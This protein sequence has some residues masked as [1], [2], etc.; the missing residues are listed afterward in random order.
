MPPDGDPPADP[1][2]GRKRPRG[3]TVAAGTPSD[4]H[5]R[6]PLSAP[7]DHAPAP[8]RVAVAAVHPSM[9]RA[10]AALVESDLGLAL[11]GT[12]G[13][14]LGAARL[15]REGRTDV[16]LID[17]GLAR[18]S[19]DGTIRQIRA[20]RPG[21]AVLVTGMEDDPAYATVSRAAGAAGFVTADAPAE[22]L[23]AAIHA[24]AAEPAAQPA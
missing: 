20:L 19:T 8:V 1:G 9:R 5:P 6:V 12:V 10:L 16:L 3:S 22:D 18:P 2:F 7:V 15:V 11:A 4:D 17:D 14:V 21:V 13:D 23:L 24:A